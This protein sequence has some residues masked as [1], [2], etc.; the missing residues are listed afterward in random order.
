[1]PKSFKEHLAVVQE[2]ALKGEYAKAPLKK[3]E[4]SIKDL[5]EKF[6]S[7]IDDEILVMKFGHEMISV[8]VSKALKN[9][10]NKEI[11]PETINKH[12]KKI[13]STVDVPV[14]GKDKVPLNKK[15][16]KIK[17]QVDEARSKKD[18]NNPI[19]NMGI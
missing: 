7:E 14:W 16:E 17:K 6:H 9:I 1:M 5:E 11:N 10:Q 2:M 19:L 15:A 12:V 18:W 3:L 4:K 13:A 8:D